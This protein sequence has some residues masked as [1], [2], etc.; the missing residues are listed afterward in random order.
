VKLRLW[1]TPAEVAQATAQP[2]DTFEVVAVG[3][4][5]PDRGASVLV[6]VYLAGDRD[7]VAALAQRLADTPTPAGPTP[8]QLG[9][10]PAFLSLT[11]LRDTLP[12]GGSCHAH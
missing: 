5:Y 3:G 11:A 7:A 2:V 12:G 1:R 9:T 10:E 6:R 8:N 4:P